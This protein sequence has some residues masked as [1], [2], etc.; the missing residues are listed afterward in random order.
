MQAVPEKDDRIR[1]PADV[2]L[3]GV[4]DTAFVHMFEPIAARLVPASAT[5]P[6]AHHMTPC[7]SSWSVL[8]IPLLQPIA[9]I[10]TVVLSTLVCSRAHWRQQ[11][12]AQ[13]D[14]PAPGGAGAPAGGAAD[15]GCCPCG[16]VSHWRECW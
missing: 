11:H 7:L 2:K 16:S 4:L 6:G 13:Q 8:A 9:S 12:R 15:P 10:C 5:L 1:A 3:L 14:C